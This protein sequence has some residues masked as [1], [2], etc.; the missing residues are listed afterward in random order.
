[1]KAA[2]FNLQSELAIVALGSN[3]GDS[4]KIV[5]DAMARLQIFSDKPLLRSSIWQT[6]PVNCPPDSPKFVN[7]VVGL[8]PRRRETP[9]SLLEKLKCLEKEFGRAPKKILNEPRAL[10]LDLIAFGHEM[11]QAADLVLP[12]PRAHLRKFVLK[13]LNEIAPDLILAGREMA[14]SELLAGLSSSEAV[15]KL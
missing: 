4:R 2:S 12:H 7:A 9:E 3:L 1:M 10:D 11:R 8:V 6:S 14:V 15:F 13:P 5:L